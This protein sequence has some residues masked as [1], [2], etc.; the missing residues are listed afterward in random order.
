MFKIKKLL[1]SLYLAAMLVSLPAAAEN[2]G[3]GG[4]NSNSFFQQVWT[5]FFG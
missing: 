2:I 5:F 1:V 3:G 4:P